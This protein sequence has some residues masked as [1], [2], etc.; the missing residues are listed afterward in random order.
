M[1]EDSS[2]TANKKGGKLA[3]AIVGAIVLV[4]LAVLL[5]VT[6][7]A[8]PGNNYK[9]AQAMMDAGQYDQAIAIFG[10]LG[11]YKDSI[12]RLGEAQ[13]AK[14]DAENAAA[15]ARAEA[16]LDAGDFDG[17]IAAFRALAGYRDSAQ[18]IAE[19]EKARAA[20]EDD[21]EKAEAYANAETLVTI[22]QLENAITAF[23]ALGDYKDSA[24]RA[25]DLR[26]QIADRMAQTPSTY[27]RALEAFT[28]LG[29][30]RD[31]AERAKALEDEIDIHMWGVVGSFTNWGVIPDYP[32][33]KAE[34][35]SFRSG[36]IVMQ[37]GDE[38][39]LRA[40]ETWDLSWGADG[41]NGDN[42]VVPQSGTYIVIFYPSTGQIVLQRA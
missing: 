30:Y 2:K 41:Q 6:Q 25:L 31:S 7:V 21:A 11:N 20:A 5:L 14:L 17:A 19:V 4:G 33:T 15:Y 32:M 27:H 40:F 29:D 42:V 39:K 9:L 10:S 8:I 36:P 28:A 22:G 37:A 18:R 16:L 26:Y 3:L 12:Q 38:F 23:E 13:A 35:G 34:D 24:E 1:G